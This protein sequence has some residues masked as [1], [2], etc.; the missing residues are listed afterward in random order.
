[1]STMSWE[2][3]TMKQVIQMQTPLIKIIQATAI[4]MKL[5]LMIITTAIRTALAT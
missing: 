1:M 4:T 3:L 5:E 2:R